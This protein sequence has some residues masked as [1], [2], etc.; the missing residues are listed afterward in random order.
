MQTTMFSLLHAAGVVENQTIEME[1]H[2]FNSIHRQL[3]LKL[4]EVFNM[5]LLPI[6]SIPDVHEM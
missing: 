5:S 2:T 4:P 6:I 1:L 3:A